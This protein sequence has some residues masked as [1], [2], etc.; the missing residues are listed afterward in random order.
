MF[1]FRHEINLQ[2]G[3]FSFSCHFD[4]HLSGRD[5]PAMSRITQVLIAMLANMV[6]LEIG[7]EDSA[8]RYRYTTPDRTGG[9]PAPIY[10]YKEATRP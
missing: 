6:H 10:S 9:I 2:R 1:V 5:T 4:T 3:P 8:R 7:A